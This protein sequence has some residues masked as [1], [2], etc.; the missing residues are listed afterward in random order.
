MGA[1]GGQCPYRM[2]TGHCYYGE[3]GGWAQDTRCES[4]HR[5]QWQ[6]LFEVP[7]HPPPPPSL[8]PPV[9]CYGLTDSWHPLPWWW[10]VIPPIK[11]GCHI[12]LRR[13]AKTHCRPAQMGRYWLWWLGGGEAFI[14]QFWPINV[15]LCGHG[16][17]DDGRISQSLW[18]PPASPTCCS[19]SL[20]PDPEMSDICSARN[21][22]LPAPTP[23]DTVLDHHPPPQ[24]SS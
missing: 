13:V 3:E 21:L 10:D 14:F 2:V 22:L 1:S 8:Q 24:G 7:C 15:L 12:S 11:Y 17:G 20:T 23:C 19:V 9:S 6:S 16:N 18:H 4:S 5:H